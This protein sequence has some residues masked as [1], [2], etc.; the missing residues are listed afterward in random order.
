M[1]EIRWQCSYGLEFRL[2]FS[3]LLTRPLLWSVFGAPRAG[4]GPLWGAHHAGLGY[5]ER[6]I[7]QANG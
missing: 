1:G 6:T 7:A 5:D 3:R 2:Q 4:S